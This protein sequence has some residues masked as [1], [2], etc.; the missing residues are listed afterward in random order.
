M[1]RAA[2]WGT[3]ALWL[4]FATLGLTY[5]WGR[6]P[7]AIPSPPQGFWIWLGDVADAHCCEAMA[8]VELYYMLAVAFLFASLCTFVAW[9]MLKRLRRG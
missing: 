9:R 3:V 4:L 8:D 5:W 1:K 7:Q 6:H 2:K